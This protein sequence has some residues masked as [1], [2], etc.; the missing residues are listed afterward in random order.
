[1]LICDTHADTL[2]RMQ[3]TK[4][5]DITLKRLLHP[6]HTWVQALALFVGGNGLKGDDRFLIDR[7]LENFEQLKK[8]GFQQ[9]RRIEEAQPDKANVLLTIEGGEAFG[10]DLS[11]VQRFAELGVRIAALV[12]NNENLLAHPAV[13]GSD[14]GLTPFGW[15]VAK[16]LRKQHIA[17][18]IS[19]LNERGS[20]E[21]MESSVPPM[22]SHS[23]A[24]AL[25][26]HPR[27][28][29]DE[30]LRA[31]FH[32]GGYVGVNFYPGFLKESGQA[33]VDD[34][35]DHI[36][37]MCDLG[38]E[39]CVGLGSDFDGIDSYP[40]GLRTP[41]QLP[42]LFERMQQRGFDEALIKNVAGENF[43]RY[44]SQIDHYE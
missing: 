34:L 7:E 6:G 21:L 12:W 23:C 13:K 3:Y 29:T 9:I 24:R 22:A 32:A 43:A 31:L 44:L 14:N 33:T 11:S 15:Q 27:N 38:G 17:L 30:Q 26:D 28:L 5:T 10:D 8:K 39:R 18:D 36:A 20:W 41:D 42:A 37:Y 1:M 4:N 19:H 16:E 40:E 2:Y 35:I 25:C